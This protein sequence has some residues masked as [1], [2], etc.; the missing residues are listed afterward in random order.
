[1]KKNKMIF[2]KNE[3]DFK[4]QITGLKKYCP[5]AYK[6][7]IFNKSEIFQNENG[8]Y[9]V[10]LKTTKEFEQLYGAIELVYEVNDDT[11]ILINLEPA[12]FFLDAH[13]RLLDI[14][15]GMPFRNDKDKFKIKLINLMRRNKKC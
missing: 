11:I 5:L 9:K 1:M 14:Y 15:E 12:D 4:K 10:K 13:K 8:L 2:Y 3:I 6:D 7:L